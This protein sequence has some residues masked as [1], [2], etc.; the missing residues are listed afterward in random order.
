MSNKQEIDTVGTPIPDAPPKPAA[1]KPKAVNPNAYCVYIGPTVSDFAEN[2]KVFRGERAE[3]IAS[4]GDKLA[5][6]PGAEALII[7]S[8]ELLVAV[9]EICTP[10]SYLYRKSREMLHPPKKTEV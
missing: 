3:V 4:L 8:A 10:G 1:R 9:S 2:G 6:Y 7:P 5:A